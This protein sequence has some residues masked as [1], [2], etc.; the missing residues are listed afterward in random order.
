MSDINLLPE[1]LKPK[2]YA[3][4]LSKALRK[5]ATVALVIFLAFFAVYVASNFIFSSQERSVSAKEESY[6]TEILALEKSEQ[7]YVLVKDRLAK[8]SKIKTLNHADEE[9]EVVKSLIQKIPQD[10]SLAGISVDENSALIQI[11]ADNSSGITKFFSVLLSSGFSKID[12]TAFSYDQ[13]DHY[14]IEVD[15]YK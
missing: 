5:V 13:I 14:L 1:E 3:V 7:K 10:V 6:K 11:S 2:G 15:I 4:N 9:V 12:L 8:S